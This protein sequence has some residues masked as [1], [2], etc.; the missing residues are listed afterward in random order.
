MRKIRL[1]LMEKRVRHM[2]QKKR[3]SRWLKMCARI[4]YVDRAMP[5]FRELHFKW[6]VRI[7]DSPPPPLV[8]G[9][10]KIKKISN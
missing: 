7:F 4:K 8:S 5:Y 1:P 10:A 3:F 2:S 9:K 6:Q